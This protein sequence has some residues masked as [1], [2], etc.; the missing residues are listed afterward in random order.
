[1][2][3]ET[4]WVLVADGDSARFLWRPGDGVPL[5]E[6]HDLAVTSDALRQQHGRR[7]AVHNGVN[8]G[9]QARP[10]HDTLQNEDERQ[11]LR[12]I[13]G[14]LNLAVQDAVAGRL[15]IIAPPRA[16]GI[17]RDYLSPAARGH[18]VCEI[19]KDLVRESVAEINARL[20][21]HH[22]R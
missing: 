5:A 6:L 1:M 9:R 3:S 15:I 22:Q 7:T 20:G 21:V 4:T 13:A 17:L 16:M 19:A 12:H 8:H 18:V 14:R 2:T 11:F 10:A